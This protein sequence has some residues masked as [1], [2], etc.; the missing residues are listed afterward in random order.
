MTDTVLFENPFLSVIDRGGYF[1]SHEKRANGQLVALLPYRDGEK[2]REYLA[3]IEVCPA[4][5]PDPERCSIT[6]GVDPKSTPNAAALKELFEEAGYRVTQKALIPLGTV[7]PS[8]SADTTV[9]LYAVDVTGI[10]PDEAPGD[11]TAFEQG[12]STEWLSA[13]LV[14]EQ[15]DPLLI[16]AMARINLDRPFKKHKR[17]TRKFKGV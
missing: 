5:S 12:A 7:R 13:S 10:T 6:G 15:K 17:K 4:H 8:K 9:H 3:R 14:I 11:N 16:A 2:E 1:F